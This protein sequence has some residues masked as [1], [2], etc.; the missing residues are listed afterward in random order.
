MARVTIGTLRVGT[1][2]FGFYD[3]SNRL[4]EPL[5]IRRKVGEPSD[6]L[7]P[8]SKRLKLQRIRLANASKQ[9]SHLPYTERQAWRNTMD[10]I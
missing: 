5:F 3:Q 2:H 10:Y 9:W 7:H 4:G 1:R 6:T 8:S